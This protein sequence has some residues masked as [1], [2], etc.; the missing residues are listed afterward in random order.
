MKFL[1]LLLLGLNTHAQMSEWPSSVPHGPLDKAIEIPRIQA[2]ED[3]PVIRNIP[4]PARTVAQPPPRILKSRAV[5]RQR[6]LASNDSSSMSVPM[7]KA[8]TRA[9]T[10]SA[11]T[12]PSS[13]D[14]KIYFTSFYA[15]TN[16]ASY[17]GT[18]TVQGGSKSFSATESNTGAFGIGGGYR[19][20]PTY[21]FGYAVQLGY[22]FARQAK[23]LTGTA[24]NGR[25][26]ADYEG[27]YAMSMLTGQVS[28]LYALNPSFHI[29]GGVNYPYIRSEN[30]GVH[31]TGLPGYQI[32]A[33]YSLSPRV[34]IQVEYRVIRM[35]GSID[36]PP[37]PLRIESGSLP[38]FV[39]SIDYLF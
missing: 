9:R 27:G 35:K 6:L 14:S 33:G 2:P 12:R 31:L 21:G 30:S 3:R 19:Q 17:S 4:P 13:S 22:E 34:A 23:G 1:A 10:S 20:R 8:E 26:T 28:G 16:Q 24:G 11:P 18:A 25:L 32:G 36:M 29:F 37:T 39:L 7:I 38:G 15:L 5:K